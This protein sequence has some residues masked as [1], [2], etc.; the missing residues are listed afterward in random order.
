MFESYFQKNL[1]KRASFFQRHVLFF[2]LLII[3]ASISFFGY[4]RFAKVKGRVLGQATSV[5]QEFEAA[6]SAINNLDFKSSRGHFLNSSQILKDIEQELNQ[7]GGLA[8][9]LVKISPKGRNYYHLFTVAQNISQAGY[10]LSSANLTAGDQ[11]LAVKIKVF[12]NELTAARPYL[13]AASESLSKIEPSSL[14]SGESAEFAGIAQKINDLKLI[15]QA[16]SSQIDNAVDS[17]N[18]LLILL[19]EDANR[20]YLLLFQNNLEMRPTGGFI[21]S[22]AVLD[23]Y[24]GEIQ[25]LEV[26]GGGSYDLNF[27]IDSNILSPKPLRVLNPRWQTQDC[28]WFPDFAAS[29]QK[30]AWFVEAS[31]GVSFDAVI[32]INLP[33]IVDLLKVVGEIEMPD[34]NAVISHTNFTAFTQTVVESQKSRASGKPKQFLTDLAPILIKKIE[35]SLGDAYQSLQIIKIILGA[36]NRKD[37]LLYSAS[38]NLQSWFEQNNWAGRIEEEDPSIRQADYLHINTAT[39]NGGKSDLNIKQEIDQQIETGDDGVLVSTVKITRKHIG[40]RILEDGQASPEE[41]DFNWLTTQPNLS[42]IRLYAPLGSKLLEISGDIFDAEYLIK[43]L[44]PQGLEDEFL[45]QTVKNPLII[46]KSNTRLTEEFGKTVFGNY[47]RIDPGSQGQLTFKYK[48]P[49][50]IDDLKEDQYQ[51]LVQKQPGI[52][53]QFRCQFNGKKLWEGK[54]ERD[55]LI[56]SKFK[57]TNPK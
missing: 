43:S 48:L 18:Y 28:N 52:I 11:T 16:L 33:V 37:I 17:L 7:A 44:G 14:S 9:I 8:S 38:E 20:R 51:L 5:M 40:K 34:Y 53:S 47:L 6:K 29:A 22:M 39:V 41:R 35:G 4:Q 36:L 2:L 19:G 31:A 57:I 12:Q 54:L 55:E 42:Y 24:Q 49:F 13:L 10:I 45:Q 21:G 56:N 46:E 27:G 3:V 30:C 1:E 26:P 50:T 23:I 25:K 32:A 15:S